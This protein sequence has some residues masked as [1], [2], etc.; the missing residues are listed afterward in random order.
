MPALAAGT[1]REDVADQSAL[2][3][4]IRE[5]QTHR[6]PIG[7]ETRLR[8]PEGHSRTESLTWR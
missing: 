1:G 8:P 4:R 7:G 6:W 3:L 2:H 5:Q